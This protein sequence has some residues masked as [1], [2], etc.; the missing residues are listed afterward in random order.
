MTKKADKKETKNFVLHHPKEGFMSVVV[1]EEKEGQVQCRAEA[2]DGLMLG[3][4]DKNLLEE[5]RG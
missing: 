2:E 1:I 5:V 3:W 4:F